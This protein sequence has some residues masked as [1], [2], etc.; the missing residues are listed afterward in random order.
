MSVHLS[1]P[2]SSDGSFNSVGL[3]PRPT[4]R[5]CWSAFIIFII[6]EDEDEDEDEVEPPSPF[7]R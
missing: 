6:D 4:E 2:P 3:R 1:S 5:G 7:V